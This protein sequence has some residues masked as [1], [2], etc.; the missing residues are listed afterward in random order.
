MLVGSVGPKTFQLAQPHGI[1]FLP[2]GALGIP[3]GV[4]ELTFPYHP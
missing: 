1:L 2:H 3:D 4:A